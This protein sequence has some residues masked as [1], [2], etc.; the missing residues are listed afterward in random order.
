MRRLCLGLP[1][2][3][4][5]PTRGCSHRNQI[6]LGKH[7]DDIVFRGGLGQAITRVGDRCQSGSEP[8]TERQVVISEGRATSTD[9]TDR[10]TRWRNAS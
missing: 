2:C 1:A 7:L 3:S 9:W 6:L 10:Q 8:E 4:G 5:L